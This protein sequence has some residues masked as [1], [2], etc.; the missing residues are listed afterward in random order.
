MKPGE[1]RAIAGFEL[2]FRGSAPRQGP[3]YREEVGVF[4]VARG[5]RA[6][7]ALQSSKRLYDTPK[8]MTTQA[9]ILV[10]WRGDLYAVLGDRGDQDAFAVRLYFNP[11]V[12]LIWLGALVM[13]FGGLL[14]LTDRRL[15]VG[16]P[17]RS[18]LP[19]AQAAE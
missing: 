9:G 6:M 3:N 2:T 11:L 10:S 15:R 8:Q 16:A 17:R 7:T 12:R 4:D 5:G 18:K 14:S 19:A 1:T 13:F